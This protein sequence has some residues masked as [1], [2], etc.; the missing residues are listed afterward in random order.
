MYAWHGL[1]LWGDITDYRDDGCNRSIELHNTSRQVRLRLLFF[2]VQIVLLH[3]SHAPNE[4][5]PA[6][7]VTLNVRQCK[8]SKKNP[9]RACRCPPSSQRDLAQCTQE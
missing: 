2:D 4:F 9:K 3:V 8:F 6:R 1:G 7:L 5:G